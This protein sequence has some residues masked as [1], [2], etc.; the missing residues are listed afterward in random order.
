MAR[1]TIEVIRS[2]LEPGKQYTL[3][4]I[5][6]IFSLDKKATSNLC[7]RLKAVGVLDSDKEAH[8]KHLY[9]LIGEGSGLVSKRAKNKKAK[10]STKKVVKAVKRKY[11]RKAPPR[12][13]RVNPPKKVHLSAQ[14]TEAAIEAISSMAATI[15]VLESKLARITAILMED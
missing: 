4:D 14:P 10:R 11:V 8:G 12:K 9:T 3:A 13:R 2:H 5:G 1:L 7:Y 6:K 15:E